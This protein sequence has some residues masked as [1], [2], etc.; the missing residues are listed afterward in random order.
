MIPIDRDPDKV[1]PRITP[2]IELT[3]K[4]REYAESV[5]IEL[6]SRARKR[7]YFNDSPTTIKQEIFG[8]CCELAVRI[9]LKLDYKANIDT[10]HEADC[11]K[12]IQV[13]GIEAWHHRMI[14]GRPPIPPHNKRDNP[15]HHYLCVV[16]VDGEYHMAGFKIGYACARPE[17]W[18]NPSQGL[19]PAYFV[20]LDYLNEDFT[21]LDDPNYSERVTYWKDREPGDITP[22]LALRDS[23]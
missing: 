23:L 5:A 1:E 11:G 12:L 6:R 21:L 15:R 2:E 7:G 22:L 8:Q 9:W 17:W 16:Y 3:G 10:F 14:Y 4:D 19:K 20:P 13:R 18:D